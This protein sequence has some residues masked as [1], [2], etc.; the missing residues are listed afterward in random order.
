MV[1]GS[2]FYPLPSISPSV[3]ATVLEVLRLS[4]HGYSWCL[5]RPGHSVKIGD[6]ILDEVSKNTSEFSLTE[7]GYS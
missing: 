7:L 3:L 6:F 2:N 1:N 5:R 4:K